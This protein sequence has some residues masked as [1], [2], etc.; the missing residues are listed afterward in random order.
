MEALPSKTFSSETLLAGVGLVKEEAGMDALK[1]PVEDAAILQ[2][3]LLELEEPLHTN[4]IMSF[5]LK[6]YT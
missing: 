5:S 1:E 2:A 6:K 3:E 4:V